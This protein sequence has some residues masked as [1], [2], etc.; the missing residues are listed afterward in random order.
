MECDLELEDVW[1]FD[2]DF[3]ELDLE[4]DVD[5][6]LVLDDFLELCFRLR[7]V[8]TIEQSLSGT[9]RWSFTLIPSH[10]QLE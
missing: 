7:D 10:I 3:V 9:H 1:D 5:E 2:E 4:R 8:S 6:C